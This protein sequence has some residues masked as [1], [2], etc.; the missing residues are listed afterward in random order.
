MADLRFH[1]HQPFNVQDPQTGRA[2]LTKDEVDALL[3][4]IAALNHS[5]ID[6]IAANN[7]N[8]NSRITDIT[9]M[10][11]E[12]K[13]HGA[14]NIFDRGDIDAALDGYADSVH[15]SLHNFDIITNATSGD[16]DASIDSVLNNIHSTSDVKE[17]GGVLKVV[18]VSND[19]MISGGLL[20]INPQGQN[21]FDYMSSSSYDSFHSSMMTSGYINVA[22]YSG[23]TK[24]YVINH[25]VLTGTINCSDL[26][27]GALNIANSICKIGGKELFNYAGGPSLIVGADFQTLSFASLTAFSFN[28][29]SSSRFKKDIQP[30]SDCISEISILPV[31]EYIYNGDT[32]RRIGFMADEVRNPISDNESISLTSLIAISLG[33]L[34]QLFNERYST[35]GAQ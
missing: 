22:Y 18:T 33:A 26:R 34:K 16:I 5:H 12:V 15:S 8:L 32:S 30:V 31:K 20:K 14:T 25:N 28:S 24:K 3:G 19:I 1:D 2:Y 23:A 10:I 9:D 29:P 21:Q 11:A 27:V 7:A 17:V 4:G 13:V 6:M 35:V